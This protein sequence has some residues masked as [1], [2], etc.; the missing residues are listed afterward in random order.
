MRSYHQTK[1]YEKNIIYINCNYYYAL[2][3]CGKLLTTDIE[4]NS[5]RRESFGTTEL[6]RS[7]ELPEEEKESIPKEAFDLSAFPRLL[8]M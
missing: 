8:R 2:T 7:T 5:E 3:A 1:N 4:E 6:S